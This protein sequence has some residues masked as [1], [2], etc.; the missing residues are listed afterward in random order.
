MDIQNVVR[1]FHH[2]ALCDDLFHLLSD[3]LTGDRFTVNY[4]P[5]VESARGFMN[6]SYD[7]FCEEPREDKRD[8]V[9]IAEPLM[10]IRLSRNDH[11]REFVSFDVGVPMFDSSEMV[12]RAYQESV[13]TEITR[14]FNFSKTEVATRSPHLLTSDQAYDLRTGH[15]ED[16]IDSSAEFAGDQND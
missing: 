1:N 9:F 5:D 2:I 6:D 4:A 8:Y 14:F 15:L 10:I 16:R 3:Q 11:D 13:Y 7:S 12:L